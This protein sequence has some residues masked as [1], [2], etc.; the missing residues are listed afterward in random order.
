MSFRGRGARRALSILL[1]IL[2][3]V[4]LGAVPASAAGDPASLTAVLPGPLSGCDPVGSSVSPASAQILSLVLPRATAAAPSGAIAAADSVFVQAEV[5]NLNPLSVD[6]E[7]RKGA[8]WSDGTR[9]GLADFVAT[10]ARGAK[11]S[12]PAAPQYRL[13]KTI[14]AGVNRHHIDV[15]FK[16]PTSAWQSLFS[17]LMAAS[18]PTGALRACTSPSA[19]ADL[20]AGPYVIATSSAKQVVLVRNPHWRG[21][22]PAAAWITVRGS[23][24]QGGGVGSLA[25]GPVVVERSWMTSNTLA[26]LSSAASLSSQVDLSNRLLSVNFRTGGGVTASV[27]VRQAIAHFINRQDLVAQGPQTLDPKVAV[28]GSNLLSQGQPG[29]TGPPARSLSSVTT[30]SSTTTTI[31]GTKPT[32]ADLARSYLKRGGWHRSGQAWEDRRGRRLVLRLV[33]P[34]DDLWAVEASREVSEQLA[35]AHIPSS[36]V[37]APSSAAAAMDLRSGRSDLG[38]FARPTDPFIA[39]SAAWFS[40]PADGPASALWAGYRDKVVDGLVA[41]ASAVMNPV[42]ALPVYQQVGRRLWVMMPTLPLYTEPFVTAWTSQISGVLDNP[43][44][45]GTLAGAPS[46][47][48]TSTP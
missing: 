37:S 31:P 25:H 30:T 12:S 3:V 2:P 47:T 5:T 16:R 43:Y 32:G 9:V 8:T 18:T 28:A 10:A 7:L 20:S 14:R 36:I 44:D 45:P 38:I 48:V 11:G 41:K 35:K 39:H 6:Y 29:Y 46:W 13:V 40:V 27:M 34:S 26:A 24:R 21:R 23:L 22:T 1:S 17:P 19:A 33:V 42:N 4:G 15:V